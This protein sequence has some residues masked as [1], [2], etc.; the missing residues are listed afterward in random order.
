MQE[1]QKIVDIRLRDYAKAEPFLEGMFPINFGDICI[2]DS[3][4]GKDYG[5]AVSNARKTSLP[6][7]QE[8]NLRKV[9]RRAFS[10][11]LDQIHTNRKLAKDAMVV[12]KDYVQR[13][14]LDMK[15]SAAEYSFD[16]NKLIFYFTAPERI[17]F[18]NLVRD[19][20]GH[21]KTRIELRQIGPRDETKIFGG[22]APCGKIELCCK[23]F[24]KKF[25]II[26]TRMAK[27][28]RLP[29]Y[30]DRLL[31]SCGRL[32]CCLRYEIQIYA[33]LS[34][35]MP[36]EGTHVRCEKG[37]GVIID[38]HFLKQTVM[39]RLSDARQFQYKVKDIEII[40]SE[41]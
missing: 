23:Q 19:L 32:K 13:H 16:R 40:R 37:E 34:K 1:L 36:H 30:Q 11:D 4:S 22:I 10:A 27:T 5:L 7:G 15:L 41:L 20:A 17:D 25:D 9:I 38:V 28:Q 3:G 33:E 6:E 26:N 18:R 14:L 39:I 35:T 21:F 2:I 12:C 24:L 29:V 31:G 8:M